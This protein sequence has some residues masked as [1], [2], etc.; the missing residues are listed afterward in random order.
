MCA[1]IVIN[2]AIP[3]LRV[4]VHQKSFANGGQREYAFAKSSRISFSLFRCAHSVFFLV[5]FFSLLL[6]FKQGQNAA[7]TVQKLTKK[8]EK[9]EMKKKRKKQIITK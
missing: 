3:P 4:L 7:E 2:T 8:K 5:F 1:A 9:D 6:L